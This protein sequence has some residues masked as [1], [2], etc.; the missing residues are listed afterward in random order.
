MTRFDLKLYLTLAFALCIASIFFYV[1]ESNESLLN[2]HAEVLHNLNDLELHNEKIN[3]QALISA[4]RLYGSYDT[5]NEQL[6]QLQAQISEIAN[7]P[8][9]DNEIYKG[10]KNDLALFNNALTEK[11]KSIYRFATLN[12]LIKN[13]AS[14]VPS[15]TARYLQRFGFED[16][17]YLLEISKITLSIFQARN[18]MDADLLSGVNESIALLQTLHFDNEDMQRFN[19]VFIAHAKVMQ[20]YLPM[21]VTVFEEIINNPMRTLLHQ[22]QKSFIKISST[23]AEKLR[24]LSN[25]ISVIFVFS[26]LF[27]I[28]LFFDLE[29]ARKNQLLLTQK[30]ELRAMTD[31]LTSLKNRFAFEQQ[32]T[33]IIDKCAILLINVD[34]FKNINDFY[35]REVGDD[36]LKF[37]ADTV[38]QFREISIVHDIYRVGSDE[39]GVLVETRNRDTLIELASRFIEQIESSQFS[40]QHINLG[41]QVSIGISTVYPLLEKAD[42]ALRKIKKTR[43]KFMFYE[44]DQSFEIQAKANLTM[45]H[46]IREAIDQDNVIPHFMP[47]MSNTDLSI[48][49]Y[50]CLIRLRDKQDKLYYPNE[51]LHI[52]KEGRLYGQLTRIMFDKCIQKFA[53]ND[54]NFSLNISID[55]IEDR[56]ISGYIIERL[57]KMPEVARRLT[58]EILES[59][60]VRNYAVLQAFIERVKF[61]GCKIAIDDYGTGYSNLQHLVKLK[62][63]CLK[64]DGSLIEPMTSETHSFVAVRAI[65]EM[66]RDLGIQTTAAE[67]VSSEQVLNIVRSLGITQSQGYYIGRATTE[68]TTSPN[69]MSL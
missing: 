21:Y 63:D 43:N 6:N 16:Q 40:Y 35:G 12:S 41:I 23:E 9:F 29:K 34:G 15:M 30:L 61:C 60:G 1:N 4:Y 64:L 46:L 38:N 42:I 10:V 56:E 62:V 50:E 26:I 2:S 49:G 20:R 53:Q 27:I 36:Y 17:D 57:L 22:V 45:M 25:I 37:L 32:D 69:Y 39:F 52:A 68:L 8:L 28:Y 51:F 67:F 13:S 48:D 59:E 18:A 33:E 19:Q 58:L 11:E 5:I 3:E 14:H 55:D 65:V 7:A 44:S 24:I 47:I 54:F 31:R 66:A